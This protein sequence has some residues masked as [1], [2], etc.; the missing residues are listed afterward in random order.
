[1]EDGA[2]S[3]LSPLC[4]TSHKLRYTRLSCGAG[5]TN[6]SRNGSTATA[7]NCPG[8][9]GEGGRLPKSH[10]TGK[11]VKN[12][13]MS[14]AKLATAVDLLTLVLPWPGLGAV[15]GWEWLPEA[16]LGAFGT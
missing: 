3:Y 2:S 14:K 9:P 7:E 12:P 10:E 1:M 5:W 4:P 15:D 13:V 6:G 11:R 16:S 8:V